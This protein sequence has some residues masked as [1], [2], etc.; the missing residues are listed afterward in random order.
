MGFLLATL[1]QGDLPQV[2][3]PT[4]P[5][6]DQLPQEGVRTHLQPPPQEEAEVNCTQ[7]GCVAVSSE[8]VMML[9]LL[10]IYSSIS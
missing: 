5:Q 8:A 2:L 7:P 3:R 1:R 9:L 6:G 10:F 4:P